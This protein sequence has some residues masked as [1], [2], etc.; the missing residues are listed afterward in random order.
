M[1]DLQ[2][3]EIAAANNPDGFGYA[4]LTVRG[5]LLIRRS[6]SADYLLERFAADRRKHRRGPA[7]FHCRI[8][9]S[10]TK[11]I[12]N[13]HPFQV[14]RDGRTVIAHNGILF[15]P[16][17]TS[18]RSD[19]NIFAAEVMP[20]NYRAIDKPLIRRRLE[21]QIGTNKIVLLTGNRRYRHNHY[22]FNERWGHW[23]ES[24]VWMS[25]NSYR[26]RK[27]KNTYT[28]AAYS[29]REVLTRQRGGK[30][31][32]SYDGGQTWYDSLTQG[33]R[34]F[35]HFSSRQQSFG[36]RYGYCRHC[37]HTQVVDP[38]TKICC[39]CRVCSDCGEWSRK[40]T[41]TLEGAVVG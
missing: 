28:G 10:G 2:D 13:C 31:Q 17:A 23:T 26:E 21:K 5:N 33:S 30:E 9:T 37:R 38:Y 11:T 19:T 14:G 29:S 41:C 32:K 25:N 16:P 4:I 40:C 22:I 20:V 15:R 24:G 34:D 7:L 12:Q 3:L 39:L 27:W 35:S 8:G 18:A 1:P 6:M 36:S